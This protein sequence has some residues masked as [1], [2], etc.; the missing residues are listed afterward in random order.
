M[1]VAI[2]IHLAA[3]MAAFGIGSVVLLR[4]KGTPMHKAFGRAW[5]GLVA[6]GAGALVP[7]RMLP[8]MLFG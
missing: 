4:P 6:A 1:T 7:G 2:A 5:V 3:A 8:E